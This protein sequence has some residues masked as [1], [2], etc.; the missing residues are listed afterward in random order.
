MSNSC[1]PMVFTLQAP[2]SMG[3]S[4][5]E[6]W[7]KLSFLK[8]DIQKA[9]KH[10]KRSST[11]LIIKETQI[12]AMRYHLTLVRIAIVYKSTNNN[13]W[14]GCGEK[15]TLLHCWWECKLI[16]PRRRTVCK[17]FKKLGIELQYNLTIPLQ[18]I[19]PEKTIIERDTCTPVLTVALFTTARIW[20]QSRYPLTDEWIQ[21]LWYT[22]IQW[23]IKKTIKGNAFESVLMMWMNLE[24]II[25]SEPSHK[26]KE[27]LVY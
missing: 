18:D 23:N 19:Y 7:N 11:S 10:K 2:L 13:C 24:P 5:Q 14:R 26:E 8:E 4:R 20:K 25:Q 22:Y 3:F 27:N 12:K 16:Q 15:E 21:K 6:Y 17:F 1:D 9:N